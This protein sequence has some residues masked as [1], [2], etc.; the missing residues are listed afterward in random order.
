MT[1]DNPDPTLGILIFGT[2]GAGW[3]LLRLPP[4]RS[5][6]GWR[7]LLW[8]WATADVAAHQG[9]TSVKR[10]ARSVSPTKSKSS[11]SEGRDGGMTD[12]AQ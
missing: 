1:V 5:K 10:T 11:A 4:R 8:R 6:P 9:K 2:L 7:S 3:L 12:A